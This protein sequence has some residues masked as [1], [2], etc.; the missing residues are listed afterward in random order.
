MA[1]K[2]DIFNRALAAYGD[3][4]VTDP[5]E[6]QT[7]EAGVIRDV[8]T[9]I[10]DSTLR[11]HLWNNARRRAELAAE[12]E[13]PDFGFSTSYLQPTNPF[14]LRILM[15]GDEPS[16]FFAR[17]GFIPGRGPLVAPPTPNWV[18]EG[19][20][21]LTDFGAPLKILYIARV[22]EGELDESLA[23]VVSLRLA[24]ATC[25]KRTQSRGLTDDIK[26][27]LAIALAL[28][29]NIDAQESGEINPWRSDFLDARG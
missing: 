23:E 17:N 15:V 9:Q 10:Y 5:D 26:K 22:D 28:A 14:A 7:V 1:D 6:D 19:R 2:R 20:K 13:A 3:E 11:M 29:K 24:A 12:A 18:V 16:P 25:F 27:E 21:I 4:S 8:Y